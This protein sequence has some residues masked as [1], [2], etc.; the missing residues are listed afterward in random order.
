MTTKIHA[1]AAVLTA[2]LLLAPILAFAYGG[3]GDVGGPPRSGGGATIGATSTYTNQCV[4]VTEQAPARPMPMSE[5]DLFD[6]DQVSPNVQRLSLILDCMVAEGDLTYTQ[7]RHVLLIY[8]IGDYRRN[9]QTWGGEAP[10]AGH[11][12]DASSAQDP[13][14]Y[15]HNPDNRQSLADAF[16]TT[17]QTPAAPAPTTTPAGY[18]NAINNHESAVAALAAH[19]RSLP[20]EDLPGSVLMPED[21]VHASLLVSTFA[22]DETLNMPTSVRQMAIVLEGQITSGTITP[23]N[24]YTVLMVQVGRTARAAR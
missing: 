12:Q 23:R 16:G 18:A 8:M 14:R 2:C 11:D 17:A 19:L 7:A 10:A 21:E 15:T 20:P 6:M 13:A 1:R 22:W 24:A 3:G 5:A 4:G 9:P